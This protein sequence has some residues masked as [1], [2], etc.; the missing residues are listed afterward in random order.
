MTKELAHKDNSK[1][2]Q[3]MQTWAS[4]AF[5]LIHLALRDLVLYLKTKSK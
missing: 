3:H 1:N 4:F 2:E 5:L